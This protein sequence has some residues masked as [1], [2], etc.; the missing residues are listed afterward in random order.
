MAAYPDVL[1]QY[2]ATLTARIEENQKRNE[3]KI[4]GMAS[5]LRKSAEVTM[6]KFADE[7]MSNVSE[8][9]IKIQALAE[10]RAQ[11]SPS[12]VTGTGLEDSKA[13]RTA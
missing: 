3:E 12:A 7:V 4:A 1:E 10:E 11:R 8:V 13:R 2:F 6:Q 5:E 9:Q